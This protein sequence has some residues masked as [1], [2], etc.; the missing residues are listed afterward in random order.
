[1]SSF[2]KLEARIAKRRR[3]A[4]LFASAFGAI[5]SLGMLAGCFWSA[6]PK[7][8]GGAPSVAIGSEA[9]TSTPIGNLAA[10]YTSERPKESGFALITSGR[11]AYLELTSLVSV[12]EKTLDLQ[13]YIWRADTTGRELFEAIL[14]AAERGV[15]VRLLLDDMDLSWADNA[16]EKLGALPNLE[17]RIFNPFSG[18]E[19]GLVDLVFDYRRV[20]HRMH[21]KVFVVDNSIAVLGGRNVGDQYFSNNEEGNYRDL[22]LYAVG[23][24]VRAVSASF[25]DFWNSPWSI[26]IRSIDGEKSEPITFADAYRTLRREDTGAKQPRDDLEDARA[27]PEQRVKRAL[28][29]LIWTEKA[30]LLVDRADKPA[31]AESELLKEARAELKGTLRRDLL[32]ETAYLIPG[33]DGVERLCRRVRDGIRVRIL[34]NSFTSNDVITAYAGYRKFREPLLRCGVELYEM[35]ADA[36]FV[37]TEWNWAKPTSSAYLHT[38]AAVLDMHD[39]IVGSFNMDPRSIKFNTEIALLVRSPQLAKEVADFIE[40]GMEI[41]NAYRLSLEDG[42]IVWLGDVDGETKRLYDEPGGDVWRWVVSKVLSLLPIEG[43]L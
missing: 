40:G 31:T 10:R 23:P 29:K 35:R 9:S 38:K 25:D 4:P 26:P 37:K 42:E 7:G 13:Y 17:I 30:E 27:H 24:I 11:E 14:H 6:Q 20:N 15:R 3:T 36:G 32:L 12:A 21:N 41:S 8:E 43:Q 18:R 2:F 1:M 33:D 28:N 19:T 22:D 34:T 16:L 5:V 39:V